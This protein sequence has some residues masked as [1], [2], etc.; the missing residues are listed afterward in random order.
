MATDRMQDQPSSKKFQRRASSESTAHLSG[1]SGVALRA[2]VAF[3]AL[4]SYWV[5]GL[6]DF[7]TPRISSPLG[8]ET[9]SCLIR[10]RDVEALAWPHPFPS[11]KPQ[12][13]YLDLLRNKPSLFKLTATFRP[14]RLFAD[15]T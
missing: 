4:T 2:R 10:F 5:S 7:D 15:S 13:C 9:G 1:C 6:A 14:S 12:T 8:Y 3:W 11:E